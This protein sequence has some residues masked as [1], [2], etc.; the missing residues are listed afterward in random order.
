M[1]IK[2]YLNWPINIRWR[3]RYMMLCCWADILQRS[4]NYSALSTNQVKKLSFYVSM[5]DRKS[6]SKIRTSE[7]PWNCLVG[8][9]CLLHTIDGHFQHTLG[10]WQSVTVSTTLW[11]FSYSNC[12]LDKKSRRKVCLKVPILP[13]HLQWTS[14]EH[15]SA[16]FV[17]TRVL[18]AYL[19]WLI[20]RHLPT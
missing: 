17:W 8:L 18:S 20:T 16:N 4:F 11:N 15:A 5:V 19:R 14:I 6:I 3:Y 1:K 2:L 10:K 12:L 7:S 13:L 9:F